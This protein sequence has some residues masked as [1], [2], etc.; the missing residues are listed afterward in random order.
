MA[1]EEFY[2]FP[3]EKPFIKRN[4][5]GEIVSQVNEFVFHYATVAKA[6]KICAELSKL[7]KVLFEDDSDPLE[8]AKAMAKH[9]RNIN[10]AIAFA[11]QPISVKNPDKDLVKYIDKN[12]DNSDLAELFSVVY[13]SL[14]IE[15]LKAAIRL[16][17]PNYAT[18]T[19]DITNS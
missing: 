12:L 2:R 17:N 6:N 19:N 18:K 8:L 7:P 11:I 14:G 15:Y 9:S 1:K 13:E 10:Y 4:W 3:L 5:K 16:I